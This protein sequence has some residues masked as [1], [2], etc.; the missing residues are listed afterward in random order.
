[1]LVEKAKEFVMQTLVVVSHPK[2]E[3]SNTQQFLKES[4]AGL[5][6]VTWYHLDV[7]AE[8]DLAAET[9]RIQAADRI[10]F[11]FPLYWYSA[12]ASLKQ[13]LDA[14]WLKQVVY[15]EHGGL[16]TGKDLGFVVSF[17]Q[18]ARDYQL[19]GRE[20]FSLSEILTPY[21]ALAAKT[22]LRLLPPLTIAQFAYMTEA[23]QQALLVRYQQLLTLPQP[24]KFN[25]QAQWFIDRLRTYQSSTLGELAADQL[26]DQQDALERLQQTIS[27]LKVGEAE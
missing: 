8:F 11:Q 18:P 16:L 21:R 4:I 13:W 7:Q 15:N 5:D 19:G 6:S 9:A 26:Q 12:P 3:T 1:M 25:Q 17:S 23:Q 20:Q 2:I 22:G 24:Q 27:D 14:V 10:I